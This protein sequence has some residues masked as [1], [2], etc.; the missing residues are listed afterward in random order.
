MRDDLL[1]ETLFTSV[2]HAREAVPA[3]A[4]DYNAERLHSALGYALG[5]PRGWA[6]TSR[7]AAGYDRRRSFRQHTHRSL[8]RRPARQAQR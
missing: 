5:R 2:A 6:Q 3:W 4:D 1:N 7:V 8:V